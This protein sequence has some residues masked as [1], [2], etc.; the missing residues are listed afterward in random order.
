MAAHSLFRNTSD[1]NTSMD[2]RKNNIDSYFYM[3]FMYVG[4][5]EYVK[6]FIAITL[7]NFR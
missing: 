7:V 1:T 4:S 3:Q 5:Y 6:I 2:F